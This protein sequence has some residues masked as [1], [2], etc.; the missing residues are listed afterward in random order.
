LTSFD[1]LYIRALRGGY[2]NLLRPLLFR[3]DPEVI[4][5]DMIALLSSLPGP[6]RAAMPLLLGAPSQPVSVAG[7]AFPGRVGLAAGLDKDGHAARG[8]AP[9]GFGFAE[10][11]TVTAHAQPGNDKPRS[12]R[13]RA[14]KGLVNRM[15]FNNHGADELALTLA[16]LGQ[17]RGENALGCPMGISIG[18]T[19]ATPLDAAVPDYLASL[20]AL[21][22]HADYIAVN[23]SSPNTPGLRELQGA[24]SL[25]E[26]TG[27]IV[28]RAAEL[29]PDD[30]VPVFVKLAPDL[31]DAGLEAAVAAVV[32]AGASG[33][34]AVNT[35]LSRDG[36]APADAAVAAEAG[37]MSGAP[38]FGRALEVVRRV[39]SLTGLPLM[40]CGGIMSPAAAQ[41]FF[42]AGCE[43]VQIY[44]GFIYSGPALIRGIN[45]LT[46]P[47]R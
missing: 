33:L 17:V 18:K 6:V 27:A 14:S 2:E 10:L 29:D 31:T 11:G 16:S 23:V 7:I 8:W 43:L 35:T 3:V 9:F 34:I 22:P 13:L 38:L 44:T 40:G 24:E 15:G 21:A 39:R 5:E 26:L 46:R 37:G 12:F 30:P 36:I 47:V 41:A 45:D 32:G 4:H 20:E 19:K 1:E 42:D 28:A 25:G